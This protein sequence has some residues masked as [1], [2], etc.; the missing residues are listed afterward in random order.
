MNDP[1]G[2]I[3][4]DSCDRLARARAL[5]ERCPTDLDHEIAVTGSVARGVADESSDVELNLWVDALPEA[6]RFRFW[7]DEVGA[8]DL[9]PDIGQMDATGFCWTVCRFQG[10]WVE[11]G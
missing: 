2:P 7:L 5:I 4:D 10:V 6:R 11:I 9:K 3:T 1:R 8:T